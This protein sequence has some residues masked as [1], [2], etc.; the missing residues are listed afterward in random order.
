M[1]N[2]TKKNHNRKTKDYKKKLKI[3]KKNDEIN[4]K[5]LRDKFQKPEHTEWFHKHK[6]KTKQNFIGNLCFWVV[7]VFCYLPS[8]STVPEPS[9]SIS[10]IIS[11]NSS[12][13]SLSSSARKISRNALVGI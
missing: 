9:V 4:E 7:F 12:L 10:A 5:I 11:S 2:W 3:T 6:H 8:K 1:D 13:V